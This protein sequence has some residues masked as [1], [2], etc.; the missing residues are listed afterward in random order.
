MGSPLLCE[1]LAKSLSGREF[2]A[3]EE[4]T[5]SDWEARLRVR[6][7][8]IGRGRKGYET[9]RDGGGH[10]AVEEGTREGCGWCCCS[11]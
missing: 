10:G 5:S 7:C 11:S 8:L 6:G 1:A 9:K 4:E 2:V 3:R